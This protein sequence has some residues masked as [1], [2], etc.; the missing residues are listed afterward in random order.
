MLREEVLAEL[1]LCNPRARDHDIIIYADYYMEYM[2][3]REKIANSGLIGKG[4]NGRMLENPYIK[5][6]NKAADE[7]R[8]IR[9]DTGN[10]WK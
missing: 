6:R 10:L 7:I 2:D 8:K 9:L 3:C 1:R 5:V 4:E